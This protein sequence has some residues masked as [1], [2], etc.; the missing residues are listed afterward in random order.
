MYTHRP[1]SS[2]LLNSYVESYK[3][4]PKGT[5]MGPMG[6]AGDLTPGSC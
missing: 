6:R 5:T 2:S 1:H 3:V 4:T